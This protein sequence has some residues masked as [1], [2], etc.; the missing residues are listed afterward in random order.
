MR[1]EIFSTNRLRAM[2]HHISIEILCIVNLTYLEQISHVL[3]DYAA[4][5]YDKELTHIQNQYVSYLR[6][7]VDDLTSLNKVRRFEVSDGCNT[8]DCPLFNS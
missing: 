3:S 8:S 2:S 6:K 4:D 7:A 5:Y 1:F